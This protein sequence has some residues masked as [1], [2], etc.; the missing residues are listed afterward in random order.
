MLEIDIDVKLNSQEG[1]TQESVTQE[2]AT[3]DTP[4]SMTD[5][6]NPGVEPSGTVGGLPTC[7]C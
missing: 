4:P 2:S 5:T 6:E 1:T 3:Q 7:S